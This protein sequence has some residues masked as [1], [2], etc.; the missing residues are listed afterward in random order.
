MNKT[1]IAVLLSGNG[2]MLQVLID[3]IHMGH[4][5]AHLC[6]VGS[7]RE[8]A[9]GLYRAKNEGIPT[10][11]LDMEAFENEEDYYEALADKYDGYQCDWIVLSG[12]DS[13]LPQSFLDRFKGRV[14]G[15][16]PSLLPKYKAPEYRRMKIHEAVVE[17]GDTE[18][19]LTVFFADIEFQQKNIIV[20]ESVHVFD[21]DSPKSVHGR[22][23]KLQYA[24]VPTAINLLVTEKITYR[25]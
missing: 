17:N 7:N 4:I 1:S 23:L 14:I 19:G 22:V 11:T 9:F 25:E 20:Q 24:L 13:M 21:D 15:I 8:E 6:V 10:F 3:N 18:T 5:K 12:Y 2:S 16:H